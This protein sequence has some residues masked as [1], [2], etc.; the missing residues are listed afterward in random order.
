MAA[1]FVAFYSSF[2]KASEDIL[3]ENINFCSSK[4]KNGAQG[5]TRTLTPCGTGF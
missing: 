1:P 3:L 2:A 4:A 5:G